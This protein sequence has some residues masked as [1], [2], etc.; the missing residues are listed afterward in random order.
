MFK[1]LLL[2]ILLLVQTSLFSQ[3]VFK[4]DKNKLDLVTKLG[5]IPSIA[6]LDNAGKKYQ[7]DKYLDANKRHKDKPFLLVIWGSLEQSAIKS[8]KEFAKKNTA[9]QYNI[10][11]LFIDKKLNTASPMN[12]YVKK[13]S[14]ENS[15]DKF[16]L[17]S[18][19]FDELEKGFFLKEYP[20]HIYAAS[21]LDIITVSYIQPFEGAEALLSNIGAGLQKGESI[22]YSEEGIFSKKDD[23]NA[24]YYDQYKVDGDNIFYTRNSRS[25]LLQT[26]TYL[27]KGEDYLYN[28]ELLTQTET[29]QK[30]GIGRFNEGVPVENYYAWFSDGKKQMEYLV[31]GAA[32]GYDIMGKISF[33]GTIAN[34]LGNGI[35][36]YYED[37][38]RTSVYNYKEGVLSG[39]QKQ[40][41]EN[42][43][44]GEWFASPDFESGWFLSDGFQRV[45]INNRWGFADRTGKIIV[46]VKY[47][48]AF[49]FS[50][51]TARLKLNNLY[52]FADKTG[53]IIIPIKYSDAGDFSEGKANVSLNSL[54]GFIDKTGKVVIPFKYSYAENF[55]NGIASV[56]MNGEDFDIDATGLRQKE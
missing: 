31:N 29:G 36:T 7:L 4:G 50:E 49:D 30:T 38:K 1:N 17:L 2:P 46:P 51:C 28:G 14:T 48:L 16:L 24:K 21:N 52:G 13:S 22:W 20:K 18:T 6:V 34:G 39:I 43:E 56:T 8:L 42:G 9:D 55:K 27:K 37:E 3:G 47:D 35:F 40:F 19:D 45:K 23:A 11:S 12:E 26:I 15:W 33:E 53:K 5:E 41:L 25:K 32:K 44:E 54:Y 10:V